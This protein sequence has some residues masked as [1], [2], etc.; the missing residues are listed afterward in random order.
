MISFFK[1]KPK[2][3]KTAA[4]LYCVF[5]FGATVPALG[6]LKA[7]YRVSTNSSLWANETNT[8]IA[9][10]ATGTS[11]IVID[12]ST[13]YQV[14]NAFGGCFC[15]QG[16]KALKAVDTT[17]AKSVMKELFDTVNGC[18]F[19]VCRMPI[20]ANDFTIQ[21]A[22]L[23][24]WYS[25][26]ETANDTAITNISIA[27]DKIYLIPYIKS[28]M[29]FRPNLKIWASPWSPP[30]WMK[31]ND[32]VPA[33]E[34]IQTPKMLGAYAL[35][36]SKAVKLIQA[37]GVNVY[38][39]SVQN[40]PYTVQS[41]PNCTWSPTEIRDFIKL[42]VG[43]RFTSDQVQC[44][45]WSP[46]MNNGTFANF[47]TWLSDAGS[48]QYIKTVCFQYEGQNALAAVHAAYPN[49]TLYETETNCGSHE[50]NWAY[51]ESP[52]FQQ[53]QFY[54]AN[55]ANGYMQ[56]NMVLD[57]SGSSAW[58]WAQCSMIT[59]DTTKKTVTYNPQHYCAKH[60]SFYVKPGA[61]RIK[62][63]GTFTNQV[64]FKNPDGSVVVVANNTGTSA[65]QLA[66]SVGSSVVN[67]SMPAHSFDTYV[68]YDSTT[69]VV[70]PSKPAPSVQSQELVKI[71]QTSNFITLIAQGNEFSAKIVGIDGR[72]AASISTKT[73][74]ALTIP[75]DGMSPGVYFIKALVD[76]KSFTAALP[77]PG[78]C[79]YEKRL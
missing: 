76:G 6:A 61:K 8:P 24:R 11:T 40:E 70:G 47:N 58:G 64:G 45:I 51:A 55:G 4:L 1:V 39:L 54:F 3:T 49:L 27:R 36:L 10:A 32:D 33:A 52:T 48:A 68:F 62:T 66:V 57:Q 50:N 2:Y 77:I 56:W 46:T 72:L 67:V 78:L 42:Y 28:A 16:A 79:H 14:I 9:S 12:T 44:D 41:Y 73:G 38:G 21:T 7:K 19:N 17:L 20:G 35:Y 15:E 26:D 29:A 59:V 5:L 37:E 65:L 74:K 13:K 31:V 75:A 25:L 30:K 22:T 69:T 53:M 60:F 23:N 34:F 18:K 63:S 71:N 43:P